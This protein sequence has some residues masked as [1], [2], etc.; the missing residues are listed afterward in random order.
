MTT[1]EI[2]SAIL[3]GRHDGEIGEIAD[4]CRTRNDYLKKR[5]AAEVRL[6]S[7]VRVKGVSPRYLDGLTG[8]VASFYGRTRTRVNIEIEHIESI[9]PQ[10]KE[11]LIGTQ[12]LGV[13][14]TCCEILK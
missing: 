11:R 5:T 8:N 13:P 14:L 9:S 7:R 4:A 2:V 6:G 12:L 3:T 10:A 1:A